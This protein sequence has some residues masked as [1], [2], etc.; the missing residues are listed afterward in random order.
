M[1][2]NSWIAWRSDI[3]EGSILRS[4]LLRGIPRSRIETNPQILFEAR[5]PI[6]GPLL[7]KDARLS[8]GC[9]V[10]ATGSLAQLQRWVEEGRGDLVVTE[11]IGGGLAWGAVVLRW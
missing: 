10:H 9:R 8:A 3:D 11:A 4:G 6:L 7:R 5:Y 1:A 2:P